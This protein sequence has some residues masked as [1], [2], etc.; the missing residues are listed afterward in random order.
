MTRASQAKVEQGWLR[1]RNFDTLFIPGIATLALCSGLLV[2]FVPSLFAYVLFLDLWLL[3]Y[4]HNISTYTRLIFDRDS[5]REHRVLIFALFPVV[6]LS[7]YLLG[8]WLG[9]W[10]IASIYIYWQWFHYTRQSWGIQQAYRGRAKGNVREPAWLLRALFYLVPLTGIL[11]RSWQAPPTFL[12][13][14]LRVLPVP[15]FVVVAVGA[16]AL[17]TAAW[18]FWLRLQAFRRGEAPVAHTGYLASHCLIFSVGYLLIEDITVG[19]LVVNIWHNAQYV[20]FVWHF[21]T[22]KYS[23]GVSVKAHF[24][25]H[26]SQAKNWW[27]YFGLCLVLSTILYHGLSYAS[28]LITTIAVPMGIVVFQSLNFHHYIVDS[29]IWK[30]RKPRIQAT[31]GIAP[32]AT[33]PSV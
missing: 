16:T 3:G 5:L 32:Q 26:L 13:M 11:Y 17:I 18:F 1:D 4:H 33:E 14:E 21:N 29:Q 15:L 28:S 19:W 22:R 20:L 31:L 10:A 30:L 27:M 12:G 6:I 24:L 8:R 7:V 25:S 9:F 2:L 23:E